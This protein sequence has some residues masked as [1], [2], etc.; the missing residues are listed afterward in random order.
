[1]VPAAS[2]VSEDGS[3]VEEQAGAALVANNPCA[4]V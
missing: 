2:A 4:N 1:M 3:A